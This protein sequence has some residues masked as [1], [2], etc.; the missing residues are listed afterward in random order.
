MERPIK[1]LVAEDD[2][3]TRVMFKRT[4]K[5]KEFALTETTNGEDAL[6]RIRS[7]EFDAVL[8]D[9]MMPKMDGIELIRAIRSVAEHQPFIVMVTAITSEDGKRKAIESGADAFLKK[10][11][12]A[13]EFITLVRNGIQVRGQGRQADKIL[14][15]KLLQPRR[16]FLG[17]GIASSTGGPQTLLKVFEHM[18][19]IENAA[20][21]LVQHGPQWMLESFAERLQLITP[22]KVTLG[23]DGM[24][25]Q[26]GRIHLAPG[27]RHM[28]VDPV[29]QKLRLIDDPPENYCKPAAD[30]LFRSIAAVFGPSAVGVVLS[31][32]GKD[33]TIGC[34][35]IAA[36][37]GRVVVQDPSTAILPSMPTSVAELRIATHMF[38]LVSF[39]KEFST[40]LTG[41]PLEMKRF[42]VGV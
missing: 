40:L 31:G 22:M 21:M 26:P 19:L 38:P 42:T 16:R 29:S 14:S 30:P 8:V 5:S 6:A 9:W 15:R 20:F 3:F 25:L 33:G 4:F 13:D 41:A 23:A 11:F 18:P 35:Y 2:A 27:S 37:G 7:E 36:A 39:G 17:V 32:M 1:V 12:A 34:G 10:P 24:D 28:I